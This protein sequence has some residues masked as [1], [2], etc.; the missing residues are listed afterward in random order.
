MTTAPGSQAPMLLGM[1]FGKLNEDARRKIEDQFAHRSGIPLNVDLVLH[2]YSRSS[3]TE[4]ATCPR[5]GK[6]TQLRVCRV[7]GFEKQGESVRLFHQAWFC[8]PCQTVVFDKTAFDAESAADGRSEEIFG[9]ELAEYRQFNYF[10][11]W[12]DFWAIPT[13]DEKRRTTGRLLFP[14]IRSPESPQATLGDF[15]GLSLTGP[16]PGIIAL[17]TPEFADRR[18]SCLFTACQSPTCPC[19]ETT[20]TCLP[21]T[22]DASEKIPGARLLKVT[23]DPRRKKVT[24]LPSGKRVMAVTKS[25][26]KALQRELSGEDWNVII[27]KLMGWKRHLYETIDPETVE[28]DFPI[29]MVSSNNMADMI[30][31]FR[32][33]PGFAFDLDGTPWMAMDGHCVNPDCVCRNSYLQFFPT[34]GDFTEIGPE[35]PLLCLY[36]RATRQMTPAKRLVPADP[37]L[38]SRIFDALREAYPDLDARLDRNAAL[39]SRMFAKWLKKVP[40]IPA[41]ASSLSGRSYAQTSPATSQTTTEPSRTP[42]NI[43]TPAAG[44]NEPCPCGSGKKYKKCCG[45]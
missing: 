21:L 13:V 37:G 3:P 32:G 20:W 35:N 39:L 14:G 4:C 12:N 43:S 7:V 31:I 17:K 44:R 40:T 28:A 30:G 2:G 45:A 16:R 8:T 22:A 41:V 34:E 10:Q 15:S 19:F 36:D 27:A 33:Y 9:I 6:P 23:V 1:T 38:L 26:A 5:C 11:S 25:F 24:P 29:D 42:P 18:F